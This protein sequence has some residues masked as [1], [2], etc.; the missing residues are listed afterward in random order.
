MSPLAVARHEWRSLW[1]DRTFVATL[2]CLALLLGAAVAAGATTQR[3]HE[4]TR[5]AAQEASQKQWLGQGKKNPHSAAHFGIHAFRPLTGLALFEPGVH[6]FEGTSVY[7]EAHKANDLRDAPS[8][9]ASSLS[10]LGGPSAAALLRTLLPLVIFLLT[11]SAF[12]GERERGT[13]KLLVARGRTRLRARRGR[14]GVG[15]GPAIRVHRAGRRVRDAAELAGARRPRRMDPR[16][17]R[18][19]GGRAREGA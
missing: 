19:G 3:Q 6:P 9:D 1:R 11:A 16:G 10:R 17:A 7:L 8:E 13:L 15:L 2:A 5:S 18:R 4:R 14:G 12:A